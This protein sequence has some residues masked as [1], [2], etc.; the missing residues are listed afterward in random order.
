M[1]AVVVGPAGLTETRHP[2]TP[3]LHAQPADASQAARFNV[4]VLKNASTP[5]TLVK[6]MSVFVAQKLPEIP[7]GSR[8][9][10]FCYDTGERYFS[11]EGLFES[12]G[13]AVQVGARP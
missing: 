7:K 9:L 4:E 8:V 3:S 5:A 12:D 1:T 13:T 11:V 2:A 10:T 6:S